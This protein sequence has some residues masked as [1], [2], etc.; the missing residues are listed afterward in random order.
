MSRVK[1]NIH[2]TFIPFPTF[3]HFLFKV[4]SLNDLAFT[5]EFYPGLVRVSNQTV[6][7]RMEQQRLLRLEEANNKEA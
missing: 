1:K 2:S 7:W 4:R 3:F 5:R 6:A